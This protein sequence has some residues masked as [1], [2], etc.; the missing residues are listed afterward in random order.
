MAGRTITNRILTVFLASPSD[1][2]EERI[3][4]HAAVKQVNRM[5]KD[6]EWQIDLH[7]WE[8]LAPGY[9]RPQDRINPEV[10]AC[11]L[12]IGMLGVW[13]GTKTGNFASGFQEEY[14]RATERRARSDDPEIWLLFKEIPDEAKKDPGTQ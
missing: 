7:V 1:L 13:W 3:T 9:G 6:L 5:V 8:E 11:D 14:V 2:K 12:F 4:V 10:D